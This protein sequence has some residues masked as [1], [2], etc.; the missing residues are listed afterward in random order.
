MDH[1]REDEE[2]ADERYIDYPS[3]DVVSQAQSFDPPEVN[4][5]RTGTEMV[6]IWYK[7]GK[8]LVQ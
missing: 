8:Y 1:R 7:N 2:D 3:F 4:Y 6:S 5:N